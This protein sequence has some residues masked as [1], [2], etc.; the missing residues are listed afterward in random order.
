MLCKQ[1]LEH[2]KF[3]FLKFLELKKIF[4]LQLFESTNVETLD[5]DDML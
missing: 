3:F 1:F 2:G 5:M 4:D